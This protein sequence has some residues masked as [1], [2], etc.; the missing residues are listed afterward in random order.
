MTSK[1]KS[2]FRTTSKWKSWRKYLL[3]KRGCNCEICRIYKK[4]GLNVHHHDEANYTDLREYKFSIL[5]KEDH[6]LIERLLRRKEFDID[7]YCSNLKRVY[8]ESNAYRRN[9]TN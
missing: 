2:K 1:E 6:K 3:H 9:G 7:D 8:Q 5:C 4:A